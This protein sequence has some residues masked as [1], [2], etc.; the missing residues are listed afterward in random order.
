MTNRGSRVL[1]PDMSDPKSNARA[2]L[3][4]GSIAIQPAAD[5]LLELRVPA[6]RR[7][8]PRITPPLDLAVIPFR[9]RVSGKRVEAVRPRCHG[10]RRR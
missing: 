7:V 8:M 4:A 1:S 3:L 2:A 6:L 10:H 5:D 9:Y